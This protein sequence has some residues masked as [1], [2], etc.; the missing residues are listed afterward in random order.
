MQHYCRAFPSPQAGKAKIS[1]VMNLK[2]FILLL[3]LGISSAPAWAQVTPAP[4]Q[5]TSV[6]KGNGKISGTVIDAT[7]KEPIAFATVALLHETENKPLDGAMCDEKGRFSIQKISDGTYRLSISFLGYEARTLS[8]LSI[9]SGDK[10][11]IDLGEIL[12]QSTVKN[13]QEVEVV[14]QKD[15]VED[16]VDR[17]V[18]NAEK[19]ISNTGGTATEVLQKVPLLTVDLDGNVQ[20]RGNSNVRVL[21]NNKPSTI[22]A[23]SIAEALRQIPADMIKSVEVIT[24]PSAKYDAE[25]TAGI[26]NIIT[27]KNNMQGISGSVNLTGGNRNSNVNTNVNLRRKKFGLN[28][29]VGGNMWR[30]RGKAETTRTDNSQNQLLQNSANRNRNIS[31]FTQLGFDYDLNPKNLFAGSIRVSN[32]NWRN[33]SGLNSRYF[34]SESLLRQNARDI[35]YSNNNL[36]VDLNLDYTH[37]F[38]P[39]QELAI[40]GLYSSNFRDNN[41]NLDELNENRLIEYREKSLNDNRNEELTFQADYTHPFQNKSLLEAGAKTIL[42]RAGSDYEVFADPDLTG[43][44]QLLPALSNKF[45]YDQDVAAA[46]LAYGFKLGQKTNFKMGSRYEHTFINGNFISSDTSLKTDYGNFIPSLSVSYNLKQ[47]QT[48]KF[49]YSRRIQRPQIFF[50]NPF[51]NQSDT[52]NISYGNPN[53][54]A[55]LTDSYEIGYSTYFKALTLNGS[56]YWRQTDN[57]IESVREVAPNGVATTTYRNIAQN[58]TYG[59]SLFGNVTLFKNGNIS[60]TV[61][62]Y[63]TELRSPSLN[64]TNESWMGN[65]NLNASWMFRNGFSAQFFGNLNSPRVQLQGKSSSWRFYSFAVKKEILE[66]KGSITLNIDNP[67]GSTLKFKS[68]FRTDNA[69]QNSVSQFYNRAFRISIN[70]NF[71]KLEQNKQP[72][73][74]RAIRNDDAKQGD[75]GGGM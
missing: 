23:G 2:Y 12:L 42:R 45:D 68:D 6:A 19:D 59:L 25:G 65:M 36:G 11:T 34:A 9:S 73:R 49:N 71:G 29:S 46:Y 14:G 43:N 57:A 41:Y 31:G 30:S 20:L 24:S 39:Q 54:D 7:T 37:I 72:R 44:Y 62:V 56:L 16:K 53:L 13:L 64:A 47:S 21:I 28:A 51:V 8:N 69:Y 52:F 70:Y 17:L 35:V 27:K 50:L 74:R 15:L 26:V 18:Y 10:P 48:L 5:N 67:F 55:E 63:R 1:S 4:L 33:E 40:L 60:G 61:N 58:K 3:G 66:K 22:M 32:G 38:K 75:G